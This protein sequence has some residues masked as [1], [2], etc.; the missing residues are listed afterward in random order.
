MATRPSFYILDAFNLIFQVFHAIPEMTGPAG[1]PTQA[2]FGIFRDL[3]NLLRDRKPDYLA[4]AFDGPGP[5]F[6][7]EIYAEYKANRKEMPE[8]LVPQIPVIRRV[9]EGFRVPVLVEPGMEA[10]DVIA[11]LTRRGEERGLDVYIVTADKDARQLINDQV[12]LLN[13]RKNKVVDAAELEKDWGIR[14]DQVVDFLALTGDAVDNVPGVPGIGEGFASTFL[15]QFGTLDQLLANINQVK[16]P[17]K[18]Q[19]LREHGDT[20]RRA[21]Q[22]VTLRDDLPLVLDWDALKT[23]APDVATLNALCT[24]CGFH[25]FRD[26]LGPQQGELPLKPESTWQAVY[27]T[28][29]TPERFAS[30]IDDLK[31]EAKFCIDT[32]TT[33]IDPLRA[34][35]VGVSVCWKAG[36]AYYLPLRGPAGSSLLDETAT[37]A[38]LAPI[39]RDPNVEKVGQNIKYDMLAL[40]RAGAVIEGP[41]TDTMVLS[42][43]LESGERNHN[44]DQLSVRLLD[45]TMIPITDLIGKGKSQGRMD[46]VAIDRVAEYAGEDADATWRIESILAEKVREEGLWTL[47]AELERPL[48][49][50]LAGMEEAGIKVDIDRL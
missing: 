29:D 28:I 46:Q 34:E 12:R 49:A 17:K 22:L 21:R 18:Q 39:L 11:T 40:K 9:I 30:F 44:L 8:D 14:P 20:A 15:K 13:L 45:H 37:L 31:R 43:L 2:V 1:Q 26:E 4:A 42:Y 41:V 47:Y 24:E 32:E 48:I 38:A 35:V 25:R 23:R 33:A 19:S 36:E 5:V 27:H 16:G 7:S 50:V 6:R 10:D 3:L